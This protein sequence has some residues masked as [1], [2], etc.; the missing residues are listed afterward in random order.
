MKSATKDWLK[1]M[2]KWSGGKSRELPFIHSILPKING[3][4]IEP[5]IG[6][7]AFF[8]SVKKQSIINDND[9]SVI[10]FYNVVKNKD[11]YYQL[12]SMLEVTNKLGLDPSMSK[13]ACRLTDGNLCNLYYKSRDIINSNYRLNDPVLWAHSFLVVRQ[14]C[15][16]GMMRVTN[17]GKFNVPFGWYKKFTTNLSDDHHHFLQNCSVNLGSFE[18]VITD[19]LTQ[20][21]FIFLDPPYINRAGYIDPSGSI[22]TSLHDLILSKIKTTKANWMIVHCDDPYYRN[23]YKDYYILDNKFTYSQNFK[24]REAKDAKVSHLYIT[25]Y[26][27]RTK[28]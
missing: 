22:H 23:N 15:F 3:K 7:G 20:D 16:S 28:C 19:D 8:F 26:D 13:D 6:G 2:F 9:P 25:N 14:L 4:I 11:T 12:K 27:T 1:P 24:G 10:N 17:A 5:F 21:D 18:E